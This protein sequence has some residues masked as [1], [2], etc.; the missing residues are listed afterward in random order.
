M[1]RFINYLD[2]KIGKYAIPNLPLYMVICYAIGYLMELIN[3]DIC[4]VLSLNPYAILHGQVWRLVSWLLIPPDSLDFWTLLVL[5]FYFSI[6]MTLERTWGRFYFNYYIFSGIIFTIIGAFALYGYDVLFQAEAM[7]V[8]NA[9]FGELPWIYGIEFAY[10][11]ESLY[12]STFYVNMS[13]FLA[14]AATYPDMQ[15]LIFFILPIKVKV[16]AVIYVILLA[17]AAY[18]MGILGVFIIGASLLN[19]ILFFLA[20]RKGTRMSMAQRKRQVEYKRKVKSATPPKIAKHKCAICGRT[21]EEYPDLEFRFCSKCEGN[22]E[23][24]QEHLF[25]HQH[26]RRM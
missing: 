17:V 10:A 9:S 19:F 18:R 7:A 1:N 3:P 4:L 8:V 25:T 21:A 2:R 23:Y 22:Y 13:I 16:L 26:K 20:T 24:C 11:A 12:F 15:V 14:F 5:Y 6:G